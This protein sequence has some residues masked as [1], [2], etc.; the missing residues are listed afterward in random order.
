MKYLLLF[1]SFTV[2]IVLLILG[3]SFINGKNEI[4]EKHLEIQLRDIGH[5]LLL[6]ANDSTSRVLPIVK[7]N[8][9]TYEIAFQSNFSFVADT[10][11]NLFHR[12]FKKEGLPKDYSVS[13]ID[14]AESETVF[15]FEMKSDDEN[16]TPCGGRELEV[17]CYRIQI[18]FLK[19]NKFNAALLWL[20][21]IPVGGFAGFYVKRKVQKNEKQEPIVDDTNYI[22][23]GNFKFYV[24]RN[25]LKIEN[26]TIPLSEKES[27]ALK[28]FSENINQIIEREIL[29]KEI[30]EERGVVVI[31][32]NVDVLVSKL[33]KKLSDDNSIKIINVHG[34]GY[35]FVIE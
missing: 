18:E 3:I 7:L 22:R 4:P 33:R 12:Q 6:S 9:K 28:I 15:A 16:L 1:S 17:G 19:E 24:E 2:I 29:M 23:L 10:L 8:D 30:W 14:C 13:V 32:R 20:L 11:I 21:L 34:R 26:N 5:R 27:K 31:S 25:I 35:K